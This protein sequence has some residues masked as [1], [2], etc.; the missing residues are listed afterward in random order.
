LIHLS[1][2]LSGAAALL[3]EIVWVRKAAIFSGHTAVATAAVLAAFMAGMA[4]GSA[5][6]GRLADQRR[7]GHL[8][9]YG[10]LELGIALGGLLSMALLGVAGSGLGKLGIYEWPMWSRPLATFA[11]TFLILLLPTTLMGATLPLLTRALSA[12]QTGRPLAHLYSVNL[13]GAVIGTALAGFV[14]LPLL[15]MNATVLCAVACNILAAIISTRATP[16]P[17][18]DYDAAPDAHAARTAFL[19]RPGLLLALTGAAAMVCQVAWTRAFAVTLGSTTYAFSI[20][21]LT[22]LLGLTLGSAAFARL[23]DRL[24]L[25]MSHLAWLLALIG[26][27]VY[28][29]MPLWNYLP[30]ILT[31]LLVVVS[32]DPDLVYLIQFLLCASVMAAPT[33]LMGAV[34]PWAATVGPQSK[35]VGSHTGGLYAANT[36][37]AIAGSAIGGLL[38]VPHFGVS[39]ALGIAIVLYAVAV[40]VAGATTSSRALRAVAVGLLLLSIAR[41][42]W[43][44][45]MFT[46]GLFLYAGHFQQPSNY[47]ELVSALDRDKVIFQ[48]DG[49]NATVTVLQG[50]AGARYLR[51]NGKTD[52]SEAGDLGTQL[53]LGLLPRLLHPGAPRRALTIGLGSGMTVGALLEEKSLERIDVVEIEPAVAD[54]AHL[55]ARSNHNALKDPRVRLI[56]G[57]ARQTLAAPGERYDLI[58]S[59]PSNP[60]VAGI[61]NLFTLEAF[62]LAQ[63][64]LAP[65][66]IYCQW[67]QGYFISEEDVRMVLNTFATAFPHVQV[68]SD[69][70]ADYFLLGSQEPFDIDYDRLVKRYSAAT[71]VRRDLTRLE[72]GFDHPFTLISRT[73]VVGNS[74]VRRFA[75]GANLHLDDR[76]TLEFTG[77]RR[78]HQ[79]GKTDIYE[80]LIKDKT[81]MLPDG[82]YGL[83]LNNRLRAMLFVITAE[84]L[85]DSAEAESAEAPIR[86]ALRYDPHSGR[87][88]AAQARYRE[89]MRAESQEALGDLQRALRFAPQDWRIHLYLG[90][91]LV[92]L[93]RDAEAITQLERG[94]SLEPE[95]PRMSM[96]LAQLYAERG[97]NSAALT[98][99]DATLAQPVPNGVLR[100]GLWNLRDQ[101]RK[102]TSSP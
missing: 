86:E 82:M 46:S 13:A 14:L 73:F 24:Q 25:S 39:V 55:F 54:A 26:L 45:R 44:P 30:Y 80:S 43:S 4:L 77:P 93:N 20:M 88:W 61:A 98:L 34:F 92:R 78:I 69:G 49:A 76:P 23:R 91:Q 65:R 10:G 9:L 21:L 101:L 85:L 22:F 12:D 11:T 79:R 97:R 15:G 84:A 90:K 100:E 50:P 1:F 5:Y 17:A 99:L 68:F 16:V 94:L 33:F 47:R 87:A 3:Y 35:A 27:T 32:V 6:G 42:H 102:K 52:A 83:A 72:R 81:T 89:M 57:D 70:T 29:G 59:E 28:L 95:E 75:A 96:V 62:Q 58:I 53:L 63:Q 56:F 66:G 51:V 18:A 37:G 67:L 41:P 7:R 19:S 71:R 36:A 40:L 31:R 48:R 2:F 38:L 8:Q 64:R 60:W 74:D